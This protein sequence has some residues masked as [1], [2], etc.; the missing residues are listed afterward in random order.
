MKIR[1]F[2]EDYSE[3]TKPARNNNVFRNGELSGNNYNKV[4]NTIER[5]LSMEP[6]K[7]G[8]IVLINMGDDTEHCKMV[9]SRPAIV[10]GR[11]IPDCPV[12]LVIPMTQSFRQIDRPEHI[13]I[14]K[15]D[16]EN[17]RESGMAMCEQLCSADR[18]QVIKKIAVITD[19]RLIEKI[20]I[21][22][23]YQ[24]ELL[25]DRSE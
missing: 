2:N 10:C 22:L 9:G 8:D 20:N 19:R 18:T 15:S 24:L 7:K 13:F 3:I 25:D 11:F 16:C 23:I 12:I 14:D 4:P 6:V 5:A 1:E 21:A 17:L